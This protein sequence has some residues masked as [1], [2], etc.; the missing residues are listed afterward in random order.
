M[1][2]FEFR[3]ESGCWYKQEESPEESSSEDELVGSRF[4]LKVGSIFW[5]IKAQK[6]DNW[7][8]ETAFIALSNKGLFRLIS[9]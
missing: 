2:L 6:R 5:K 8:I 4:W 9:N 3:E 1:E 7:K